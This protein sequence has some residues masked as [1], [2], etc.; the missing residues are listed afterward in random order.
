MYTSNQH[1]VPR[2][3]RTPERSLA[4][5]DTPIVDPIRRHELESAL[6]SC[7][8]S[9]GARDLVRGLGRLARPALFPGGGVGIEY[10]SLLKTAANPAYLRRHVQEVA[11]HLRDQRADIL[12]V[13]GMSGYPIGSMYSLAAGLPALLLEKQ[14]ATEDKDH[15]PGFSSFPPT[16]AMAITS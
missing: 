9:E 11:D 1:A 10:G 6:R 7:A 15:P 3:A 14:R 8:L 12:I 5:P 2:Y 13:P 16:P 4:A